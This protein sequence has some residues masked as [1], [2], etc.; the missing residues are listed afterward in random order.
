M[1]QGVNE[2]VHLLPAEKGLLRQFIST[3]DLLAFH[4][5]FAITESKTT[6]LV[7][8]GT[9]PGDLICVLKGTGVPFVI[10]PA[11]QG[12]ECYELVGEAYVDG[13]M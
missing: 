13:I 5:A 3:L 7:L 11:P 4:R 12:P 2:D 6:A 8:S 1:D 10:L 9:R